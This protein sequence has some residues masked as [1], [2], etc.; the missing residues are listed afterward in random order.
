MG[1]STVPLTYKFNLEAVLALFLSWIYGKQFYKCH[2]EEV[3]V[4]DAVTI[5]S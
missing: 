4:L 5:E 1:H 3:L 2:P